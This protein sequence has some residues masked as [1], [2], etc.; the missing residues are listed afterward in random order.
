MLKIGSIKTI[1]TIDSGFNYFFDKAKGLHKPPKEFYPIFKIKC[2]DIIQEAIQENETNCFLN[3]KKLVK[4]YNCVKTENVYNELKDF[5]WNTL[6]IDLSFC[7][8]HVKIY[9][10]NNVDDIKRYIR[11][12]SLEQVH[13][14]IRENID[15][16]IGL[17]IYQLESMK[18][19]ES[20]RF[21][22]DGLCM[23]GYMFP[24]FYGQLNRILQEAKIGRLIK[25]S[26]VMYLVKI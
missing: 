5:Y 3:L 15:K 25:V 20:Q 9:Y 16:Y 8:S 18:L 1:Q 6:G 14:K 22:V 7:N 17:A 19:N 11:Y 2:Q 21:N 12:E 24:Y 10:T 26:S 23:I 4:P 13:L